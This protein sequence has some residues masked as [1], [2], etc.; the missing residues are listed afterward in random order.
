MNTRV[1]S[2]EC[3]EETFSYKDDIV[4]T[5]PD[6]GSGTVVMDKEEYLYLLRQASIAD[7]SKFTPIDP[8]RPKTR[9]RP[10]KHFHPLLQKEKELKA[11]LHQ[12]LPE[13]LAE[14]LSPKGS[15]LAHLCGLPKTHKPILSM[16][17]ILSAS[18]IYNYKL[19]KWLE[20]KLKPFSVNQYT[21]DDALGFS[22]EIRKHPVLED[23]ILVSYDVTSLFTNVPVQETINILVDKA[24]TDNC[25]N[26]MYDLNLQKDQLAQLL[27]MASTNQL[28]QFDG[29]LY[30]QCEGVAMG[31][32]LGPLLA[33]VFMC[34]LEER[35]SDNDLIPPF[36]RRYVDETLAIVPGLDVAESFLDALNGLH[37]SIHFTMELSN[38]G[39][40]PFIGMSITKNGNK[41]ETQVYRKPTDTGLLLHFQSHTDLRYK[42]GLIETMFHRAKELSSTHQAFVDECRHLKSMFNHLGYPSSLVNGI[43]DKC[44]YPSTP[45]AKT[46]SDAETLRVSIPFKDQVS[47]NTVKRQMRDLSSKIGIDVQPV[48]TSKNLKLKEIK[49]RIVNQHSVVYCFKCDLCD[50]NYVGYTTRH[51]FQRIA[52]HRYSA[53][54]RH[55]RDAHGNID[56]LNES[57]F[58]TLKK[59]STK[60]DCLVYEMLYIRTIRPNLNT[61]SDSIRAKL[62]V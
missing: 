13:K 9:G 38:N 62:F 32:P 39:L 21:I 19:A 10:A 58:R 36:Y 5:R 20:E 14:S 44:D 46:K 54:G 12:V 17:P 56:L 50:S 31:S 52:E 59:C 16:R 53:I 49:P 35:L 2:I 34:H 6:K 55:L 33:N 18:G 41:L 26:S 3:I 42:K 1:E 4:I 29:Q 15:R 60:W 30:E 8:N 24:F 57:Q 48:Y 61:Q 7:T 22:K 23:D 27:R 45:D 28:F 40:I 25:F 11:V 37:P 47:A 51:L 43:I